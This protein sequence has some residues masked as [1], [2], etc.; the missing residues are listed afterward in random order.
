MSAVTA[1]DELRLTHLQNYEYPEPRVLARDKFGFLWIGT[2]NGLIRFDGYK[3]KIY[4]PELG[5]NT[6]ISGVFVRDMLYDSKHNLWVGTRKGLNLYN[7]QTNS[8]SRVDLDD[9]FN[10]YIYD[11]YETKSGEIWVATDAGLKRISPR[12]VINTYTGYT[13]TD[14]SYK[15]IEKFRTIHEDFD[16]NIW[17]GTLGDGLFRLDTTTKELIQIQTFEDSGP[18]VSIS[19]FNETSLLV[20]LYSNA[21]GLYAIDKRTGYI[22]KP[23]NINFNKDIRVRDIHTS[24]S[25]IHWIATRRHGLFKVTSDSYQHY[26]PDDKDNR[27][28]SS[29]Q[30]HDIYEDEYGLMWFATPNGVSVKKINT[31]DI[32]NY[33]VSET[34]PLSLTNNDVYGIFVDIDGTIYI[35]S[36]GGGI[37]RVESGVSS[38]IQILDRNEQL[39][40][41]IVYGIQKVGESLF[42]ATANGLVY[43]EDGIVFN[44]LPLDSAEDVT[45]RLLQNNGVLYIGSRTGLHSLDVNTKIVKHID[46]ID[47]NPIMAISKYEDTVWVADE[48]NIYQLNKSDEII[49]S[50][51]FASISIAGG[52]VY[53]IK[54]IS[55]E[56]L[57]IGTSEHGLIIYSILE[58]K[59]VMQVKESDGLPS[60]TIYTI[61][62]DNN[63]DVWLSTIKGIARVNL[64]NKTVDVLSR[65]DGIQSTEFNLGAFTKDSLGKFYYGGTEGVS[66]FYPHRMFSQKIIPKPIWSSVKTEAAINAKDEP[67]TLTTNPVIDGELFDTNKIELGY[68]DLTTLEFATNEILYSN[69][70]I[71]LTKLSTSESEGEWIKKEG[72]N[73]YLEIWLL[74]PGNY[75]YQV[76]SSLNGFDWSEPL[77]V[78]IIKNPPPWLTWWAYSIYFLIALAFGSYVFQRRLQVTAEKQRVQK[79]IADSEERLKLALWGSRDE[80]WDWNLVSGKIHRSN[81]WGILNFPKREADPTGTNSIFRNIHPKDLPSVRAALDDHKNGYTSHYEATY[82]IRDKD[83]NWVWILDRGKIVEHDDKGKPLRMSGTIRNITDIR[84]TQEQL[85]LIAKAFENTSDG[86]FILDRDFKYRAVNKAYEKITGYK[87]SERKSRLF[88][89]RNE[90]KESQDI[91][92]QIRQSL[93]LENAWQGEL[94][95]TRANGENYTIELKLDAVTDRLDDVSHY[96]GVFSDITY[97]KK[98]EQDLR[99]MANYDQLTGLPNRSLFQ[100]RLKH[101]I[102]LSDRN[103]RE[104]I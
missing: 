6:S 49:R 5:D 100:D 91:L 40:S 64:T 65:I 63:Q 46:S 60:N 37:D 56:Q 94:E 17:V 10:S 69:K 103:S 87:S 23:P 92:H 95:D 81:T 30:L 99:R 29:E 90:Y 7:Y 13:K 18:I 3:Y 82:R 71:Y 4:R 55:K 50:D 34:S 31:D 11:I 2:E 26:M 79:L 43:T 51:S 38:N 66:S 16:R 32:N 78:N 19:D 27:S 1:N 77:S 54:Q 80:L 53:D 24:R 12:G 97:R 25:G 57:A 93:V 47:K 68:K 86:V 22:S 39:I 8:F 84:D 70:T 74:Q 76:K 75:V 58:N 102:E 28:I 101:A 35:G 59:V 20:G 21:N 67:D 98:T 9:E 15:V 36:E 14:S 62:K 88:E 96:V 42:A 61:A 85:D 41:N 33:Y 104:L 73:R 83:D 89:I 72:D 52:R 44:R 48:D 45:T